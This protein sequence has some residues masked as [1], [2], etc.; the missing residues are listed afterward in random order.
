MGG[1]VA[2]LPRTS[3][4]TFSIILGGAGRAGSGAAFGSRRSPS[5]GPGVPGGGGFP[6]PAMRARAINSSFVKGVTPLG[7]GGGTS[8]FAGGGPAPGGGAFTG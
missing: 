3:G 5:A 2:R 4:A 1:V 7:I 8:G 6:S